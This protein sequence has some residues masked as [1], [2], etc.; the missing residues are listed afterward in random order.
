ML[1]MKIHE[2]GKTDTKELARM[3]VLNFR[4]EIYKY[5]SAIAPDGVPTSKMPRKKRRLV[6]R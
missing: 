5:L 4:N 1:Q 6:R 3:F 2:V